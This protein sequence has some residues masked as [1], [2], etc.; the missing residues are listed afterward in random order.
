M[1]QTTRNPRDRPWN[2]V[3][4]AVV[5]FAFGDDVRPMVKVADVDD[6]LLEMVDP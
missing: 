6:I 3:G 5:S 2:V 4:I 1:Q